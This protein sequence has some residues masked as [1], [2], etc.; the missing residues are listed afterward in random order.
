MSLKKAEGGRGGE[1]SEIG[2]N[3]TSKLLVWFI[4]STSHFL[5]GYT[6][7]ENF[8]VFSRE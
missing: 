4:S 3:F 6:T 1:I 2:S 8:H 5:P 7:H